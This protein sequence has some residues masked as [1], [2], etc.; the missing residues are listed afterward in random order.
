ML[1]P[2]PRPHCAFGTACNA[3]EGGQEIGPDICSWCKNLSFD[4][5]YHQAEDHPD[6][7]TLTRLIDAYMHQLQRDLEERICR[8][9]SHLCACKDPQF[10]QECWRR[11]FNPDD[12]RACGTVRYR[13]QLCA[14]CYSKAQEQ[15]CSWLADCDGDRLEFPCIF[16]DRR[17]RRPVDVNWRRGPVD[18]KGQTDPN[19]EKDA[20]RHGRCGRTR[21]KNQLCQKCY[22]RLC[23]L[24]GFGRYFDTEWGTLRRGLGR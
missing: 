22:N 13:G 3:V 10:R 20:R 16:D 11:D 7:R 21:K 24:K 1:E 14:R 9:W 12:F 8:G 5:L 2:P 18:A 23:E 19:W 17:L 15:G 4:T 6:K